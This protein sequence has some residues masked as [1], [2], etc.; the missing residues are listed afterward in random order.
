MRSIAIVGAGQSALVLGLGLLDRGYAVTLVTNRSADEVAAGPV[1]SSQCMFESALQIEKALGLDMWADVCPPIQRLAVTVGGRSPIRFS[2]PLDWPAQSVDQRLKLSRWLEELARRGG[3]V[4]IRDATA[5]DLEELAARHDLTVVATGRSAL[6]AIFE[7]DGVASPHS[8]PQRALAVTYVAGA[9]PRSEETVSFTVVPGVGEV[10][11][12][13]AL[14][15]TGACEILVFEGR[16]G[17]PMDCW[18][19]VRTPEEHLARSLELLDEFVPLEAERFRSVRLSDEHGIFTGRFAPT[20]RKPVGRLPSGRYV[21][22]MA[23]AIVLNDPVTGQ[24]ANNAAKCA[25]VYLSS[26]VERGAGDFSPEWMQQTFDRYWRGYAQWAVAWTNAM[27]TG[28]SEHVVRLLQAAAELPEL[29]AAIVGGFDDPRGL[30][31][32]W[33][34]AAEA[35]RLIEHYRSRRARQAFDTRDFRRALGQFTTGVTV[36]TTRGA[37]G[38]M[39]GVTA[40]SFSS[41]SLDPP[42]VLWCLDKRAGS[43]SAFAECTHF[44]VNVLA[45]EQH[46]LSRRFATPAADKF[47]G[48]DVVEGPGGLPLLEGAVARYACR[49]VREIDAGD[50]V[51]LLGE[52][53]SYETFD[54]EPL[55]FH[56]G[57]YRVVT[58]HPELAEV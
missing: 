4:V 39:V 34:D 8:T 29:A 54:R 47:A 21:L 38:R 15:T 19:D 20:V 46:H 45:A 32:W 14:T 41:V 11:T 27:L 7:R 58:R 10:I 33:Y 56:S 12:V 52:V 13:P 3:A 53:E 22:G 37:D 24:G 25:D 17:G 57:V 23:D 16:I 26:I 6:G 50:H 35:D 31:P 49:C 28:L 2:A 1:M 9:A 40:N 18:D 30:F 42:L 48:V 51:I 5:D 43:R 36:V 55:V 44:A